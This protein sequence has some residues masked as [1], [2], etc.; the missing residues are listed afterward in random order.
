VILAEL[1]DVFNA[2][3]E[4]ISDDSD[5]TLLQLNVGMFNGFIKQQLF[6]TINCPIHAFDMFVKIDIFFFLMCFIMNLNFIKKLFQHHYPYSFD[7][8]DNEN[9]R[10]NQEAV[11]KS[12]QLFHRVKRSMLLN[13]MFQFAEEN[14]FEYPTVFLAINVFDRVTRLCIIPINEYSSYIACSLFLAMKYHEISYPPIECFC[15]TFNVTFTNLFDTEPKIILAIEGC[16]TVITSYIVLERYLKYCK[17]NRKTRQ[18]MAYEQLKS[19]LLFDNTFI[20][21]E[22]YQKINVSFSSSKAK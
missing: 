9:K 21:P 22:M 12:S 14:D 20:H 17:V 3:A 8:M 11:L 5:V 13:K 15:E 16:F 1:I 19:M 7:L 6:V 18:K 2:Y 4:P 10:I